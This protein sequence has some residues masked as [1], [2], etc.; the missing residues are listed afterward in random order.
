MN[1]YT[2]PGQGLREE[3][4]RIV[5]QEGPSSALLYLAERL[6][7]NPEDAYALAEQAWVLARLGRIEEARGAASRA[8]VLVPDDPEVRALDVFTRQLL[9]G[10]MEG[11]DELEAAAAT[12]RLSPRGWSLLSTTRLARSGDILLGEATLREG[13]R[14]HPSD[15]FLECTLGC[16]LALYAHRPQE[17]LQI[18]DRVSA[19]A[20]LQVAAWGACGVALYELEKYDEAL[21]PLRNAYAH[22]PDNET[23]SYFAGL[24][25]YAMGRPADAMIIAELAL[26]HVRHPSL[27]RDLQAIVYSEAGRHDDAIEAARAAVEER[28]VPDMYARLAL[29]LERARRHSEAQ[30]AAD[31]VAANPSGLT[32][33]LREALVAQKLLK[34]E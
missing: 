30:A 11:S 16:Y 21:E 24:T 32:R 17:A 18:L 20:S 27:L 22:G 6:R 28:P 15:R 8:R 31:R 5:E 7:V 26:P 25:L 13:L 2:Y 10:P 3:V 4:S 29:V 9:S 14:Q 34:E 12:G 23:W 1:N 33:G 19:P